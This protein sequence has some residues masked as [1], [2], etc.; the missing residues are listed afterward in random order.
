[1]APMISCTP[2]IEILH[3]NSLIR[4][5]QTKIMAL[6]LAV[7]ML[8]GVAT[9]IADDPVTVKVTN[10]EYDSDYY[11]PTTNEINYATHSYKA[12]QIL[13]ATGYDST[14]KE[15]SG[16]TW[17]AQVTDPSDLLAALKADSVWGSTFENF[18]VDAAGVTESN[19]QFTAASFANAISGA[20]T[21]KATALAQVLKSLY[22]NQGTSITGIAEVTLPGIGYYLI[23][24]VTTG[25]ND[26]A[27]NPVILFAAPGSNKI[28]IKAEKPSQDKQVKEN[29]SSKAEWN[30]VSDYSI[31]DA[32]PYKIT[33][34]VPN[35]EAYKTYNMKFTDEMSAGLTL[36]DNWTGETPTNT[37]TFNLKVTVGTTVVTENA[38]ITKNDHGFVLTLPVKANNTL[39]SWA[40]AGA[41]IT[42]EFFG[43]LNQSAVIGLDGNTN[44]SK[45]E[46]SN[47]PDDDN[48]KT[49]TP[50][51]TVIT[52]TYE[53]DVTKIDGTTADKDAAEQIKLPGAQ[54]ALKATDGE[55]NGKY[56]V[57]NA[58]GKIVKWQDAAPAADATADSDGNTALL[59]SGT[60][61]IF[62][63]I[64]LDDGKYSLEE[65]K[66]PDGYNLIQPVAIEI[67]GT[68]VHTA[69]GETASTALTGLNITAG[70]KTTAGSID[71]GI[72]ETTVINNSGATLPETG[73]IGT[74]LFYI[75]GGLLAL[76]AV[77]LLVTK[78]RMSAE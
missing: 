70:G 18:V 29:E 28:R 54:F 71:S 55:H 30:E 69:D 57:V 48:S 58:Q 27:A 65:I 16:L 23:D 39:A 14:S 33:S 8:L 19:T 73:G 15:Y 51:D 68:T 74:Q 44:K 56:A 49:E 63:I 52:F 12:A 22:A 75:G 2:S 17:G 6:V 76:I 3:P 59:V 47:N 67:V 78:R 46:Y 13:A 50:Y 20:N 25:L 7:M 77:V 41:D 36:F 60:D 31:G 45:L 72:V 11:T 40:T 24:D 53:L 43:V 21:V 66:A 9:A 64:G 34:K 42:I 38:T 5:H 61:G 37:T 35:V 32:V 10:G 26:D 1:M 62:K 4:D